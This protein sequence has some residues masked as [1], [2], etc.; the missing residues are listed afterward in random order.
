MRS[1]AGERFLEH[2]DTPNK[3]AN[4]ELSKL[5]LKVATGTCKTTVMAMLIAWPAGRTGPAQAPYPAA[6]RALSPLRAL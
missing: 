5:A 1:K 3:D 2:L 6:N 4:P